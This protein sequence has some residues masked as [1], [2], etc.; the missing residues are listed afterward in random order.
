MAN[1]VCLIAVGSPHGADQAAWWA[2]AR[3][4]EWPGLAER[5]GLSMQVCDRP[6]V[7]LLSLWQGYEHVVLMDALVCDEAPGTLI[8]LLPGQLAQSRWLGSSH[9]FGVAESLSLACSLAMLPRD[10]RLIGIAVPVSSMSQEALREA[11]EREV[12]SLVALI[13]DVCNN[14]R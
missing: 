9:G 11:V 3:L 2:L 1:S 4:R 6:G 13:D 10:L 5:P 8:P 14:A 12:P 7:A